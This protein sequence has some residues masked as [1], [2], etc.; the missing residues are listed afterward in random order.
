VASVFLGSLQM[1]SEPSFWGDSADVA[2]VF[3]GSLQMV[4]EP[5]CNAR[6]CGT[7]A[8]HDMALTGTS[9]V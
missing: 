9:G 1:V 8:L 4:S 6:S 5:G 3:L 7:G 2:S